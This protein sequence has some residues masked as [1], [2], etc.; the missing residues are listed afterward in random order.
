MKNFFKSDFFPLI[1][2]VI[3]FL[4]V[5]LS[6]MLGGISFLDAL[7]FLLVPAFLL[8]FWR[9]ISQWEKETKD[10]CVSFILLVTLISFSL[11]FKYRFEVGTIDDN[12]HTAKIVAYSI[13]NN[14]SSKFKYIMK[15]DHRFY[16]IDFIES[17]WGIFW[18]WIRW[19]FVIV[20]L[21]SL[22][23]LLL[24]RQLVIFFRKQKILSV[25]AF[26]ATSVIL[27]LQIF[28]CQQG[29]T[30]I[31]S[32]VGA[33]GALVLLLIYDLLSF[34]EDRNFNKILGLTLASCFCILSKI[35]F[36]VLAFLGIG[37]SLYMAI[38]YLSYKKII[39]LTGVIAFAVGYLFFHQ[40]HIFTK[41]GNFFYP[42][43]WWFGEDTKNQSFVEMLKGMMGS[44]ANHAFKGHLHFYYRAH[45][46]Y[47]WVRDNAFGFKPLY[48]FV[49]WLMDFS[50]DQTVTPD[51]Y[52]KG[53]GL[54]WSYFMVP[55]LLVASFFNIR[56]IFKFKS[57][58]R[59]NI[60]IFCVLAFYYY[61]FDGSIVPR[62]M[63]GFH[64]FILAWSLAWLFKKIESLPCQ[65]RRYIHPS[66][67]GAIFALSFV[68]NFAAVDTALLHRKFFSV[69]T[70]QRKIFPKYIK[71]PSEVHKNLL[72]N[73]LKQ[74]GL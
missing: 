47:A 44:N 3:A 68:S 58:L 26:L 66:L 65:F 46:L 28:W 12:Y 34:K 6:F 53:N 39:L 55:T 72:R 29:S 63:V 8:M 25:P 70:L 14:V 27:S 62:F 38:K 36:V 30:Y 2:A 56:R 16:M 17:I 71:M 11:L 64:V 22:P 20:V 41:E 7:I 1:L 19:D 35:S 61:F 49:S 73:A 32:T 43:I 59:P 33:A 40:Y 10:Y 74:K 24:W 67:V 18:R 9:M 50:I 48:V 42:Y 69:L 13:D 52:I 15:S 54:L 57:W 31:D 5:E 60:L 21:Q 23:L 4:S 37:V 51:P 45:P